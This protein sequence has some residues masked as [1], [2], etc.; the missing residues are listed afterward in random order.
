MATLS[1][2]VW[3][4]RFWVVTLTFIG[5]HS[6]R[7]WNPEFLCL[8]RA[9]LFSS[10]PSLRPVVFGAVVLSLTAHIFSLDC[11]DLVAPCP[12]GTKTT[13]YWGYSRE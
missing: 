7:P 10:T 1:I 5:L 8:P 12:A 4:S 9:K 2:K 11:V 13:T 6:I 3:R